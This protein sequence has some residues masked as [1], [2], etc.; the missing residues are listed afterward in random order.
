MTHR[1]LETTARCVWIGVGLMLSVRAV[2]T[3]KAAVDGGSTATGVA[4][5]A[6]IGLII[7]AAKGRFV[8]WKTALKNRRRI[9]ALDE[10]KPWQVFAPAFYPLIAVMMGTGIG[11]KYL[12]AKGYAGGFLSYGGLL[13]GIGAALLASS[14]AYAGELPAEAA[15]DTSESSAEVA[16]VPSA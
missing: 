9:A 4:I 2:L 13:I 12:A 7:G 1:G 6:V 8:L 11:L 3:F 14:F 15:A 16:E 10:P 5:A